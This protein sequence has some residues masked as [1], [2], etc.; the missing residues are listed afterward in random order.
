MATQ[1]LPVLA[2]FAIIL[3]VPVVVA[4]RSFERRIANEIAVLVRE[5]D[6]PRPVIELV[7]SELPGPVLRY[8]QVAGVEGRKR[9]RLIYLGHRGRF[10]ASPEGEWLPVQGEEWF[11]TDPPALLWRGTIRMGGLVP[12]R[13][14]D[15]YHRGRGQMLVRA[16][17]TIPLARSE[18]AEVAVS[19]LLRWLA[20]APWFPTALAPGVGLRWEAVDERSARATIRDGALEASGIFRFGE[21]GLI[22]G[23]QTDER[24]RTVGREQVRTPWIGRYGDY[25]SQWGLLV[26]MRA[27][28]AWRVDGRELEYADFE[29]V[30]IDFDRPPRA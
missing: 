4:R 18:G 9:A 27:S 8:L 10:R 2:L 15:L 30:R 29:V 12:V 11:T 24:Y 7:P 26:P 5:A 20:E 23:F 28:V 22:A 3:I 19:A 16:L 1:V 25:R 13:A 14:R 6:G 17:G 21:D